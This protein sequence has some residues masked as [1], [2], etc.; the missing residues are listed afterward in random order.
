MTQRIDKNSNVFIDACYARG[1]KGAGID[2]VAAIITV[3]ST[4]NTFAFRWEPLMSDVGD[5]RVDDFAKAQRFS[6][7][8]ERILQHS[9]F[10]LMQVIGRTA[11]GEGFTGYLPELFDPATGL[12]WGIR[13]LQWLQNRYEDLTDVIAAYNL[14]HVQKAHGSNKYVNQDYVDKVLNALEGRA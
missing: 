2:L 1:I 12:E 3:E 13:H 4:W 8:S 5:I 7:A 10:G 14:G 9:S 11:R 6:K